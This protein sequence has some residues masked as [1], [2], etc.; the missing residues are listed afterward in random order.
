MRKLLIVLC[1]LCLS[2]SISVPTF[3]QFEIGPSAF[4]MIDDVRFDVEVLFTGAQTIIGENGDFQG[5]G[6]FVIPLQTFATDEGQ[7]QIEAIGNPDPAIVYA[8]G[9]VD[10]GAPSAFSF[11]FTIPI[12]CGPFPTTVT[13]SVVGG[14]TDFAGDGVSITPLPPPVPVDTDGIPELQ[15]G[16]AGLPVTNLGTDVGP[17]AAFGPGPAGAFYP[18]G[19]FAA[20]PFA[21]PPGPWLLLSVDVNFLLSGG[22]DA[23]ALTGFQSLVCVPEPGAWATMGIGALGAI[24]FVLRR[25]RK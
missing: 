19:P 23:A 5:K 22:S 17:A 12:I 2:V 20:G 4:V 21:G 9:A 8:L 14:L 6:M 1:V 10:L 13:G 11:G 24:L 15:V 16:T 18:Y 7:I 25:R 3:A